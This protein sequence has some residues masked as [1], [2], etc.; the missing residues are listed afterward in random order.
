MSAVNVE[1]DGNR[2]AVRFGYNPQLITLVREV[3]GRRFVKPANGD[4]HWTVP[5]DLETCRKLR[6]LFGNSL[7]IGPDLHSWAVNAKRTEKTLGTLALADHA[8]LTRLPG[9]LRRL[10]EALYVGPIGK[11]MT[12]EEFAVAL[13]A[14]HG[15]YQTADVKFLADSPAPLNGN[16]PGLGK[17]LEWIGAVWEAGLEQGDHLVIAPTAAVDGVWEDELAYWQEDA[18]CEVGVFACT[19][20]RSQRESVIDEFCASDASVRWLVVNPAM[21][22]YRKD[23]THQAKDHIELAKDKEWPKACHCDKRE[24]PHWHYVSTYPLIHRNVWTTVNIDESHKGSVRNH[25]TITAKSMNAIK[26]AGNGKCSASSGTPMKKKG[27]DLWGTLNYLRPDVFTSYWNLAMEYFEVEDNG[28]GKKVHGLLPEKSEAF[29]R[30]LMPYMLR[31]TKAEVLPWLP[32]KQFIDVWCR[33]E[34]KQA[35]LYREMER[36]GVVN[37]GSKEI[38]TTSILA[39]FT[40]L[41]QF[42]SAVWK[43]DKTKGKLVPTADS[44]KLD[45][46]LEKMDEHGMFDEDATEKQVVFSQSREMIELAARV[47]TEHGLE[48]AMIKGGQSK[49]GERKAIK[50]AFMHGSTR[51]LCIV[52]TAGGVALTLDIADVAHFLDESWAPDDQE[53][54]EDRL[55]RA[56]RKHQVVIYNYRTKNTID[57]YRMETSADKADAHKHIL[58]VRRQL[59]KAAR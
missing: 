10:Y 20:T 21:V 34:D 38:S 4:K 25:K 8:E 52:T 26:L 54:A 57:Q 13:K 28:F 42:A 35:A 55:H 5:L 47:L 7:V 45:V 56:S 14:P 17:T 22:A 37:I 59:L 29:F 41:T 39:E 48:V 11:Q 36:E 51:V 58:D 53:Q 23:P 15:S 30:M 12:P 3:T 43:W 50:D 2:I 19:G 9:V 6:T 24:K 18:P 32:P 49:K 44:C 46:M 40:R 16:Q 1:L 27:A 31:R 33:M